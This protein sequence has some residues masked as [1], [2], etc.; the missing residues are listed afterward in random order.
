MSKIIEKNEYLYGIIDQLKD[1]NDEL[2]K[3]VQGLLQCRVEDTDVCAKCSYRS[4]LHGGC[5]AEV[6]AD[7]LGIEVS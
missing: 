7:K 5:M 1:E 6:E 3:L 2:K 4:P